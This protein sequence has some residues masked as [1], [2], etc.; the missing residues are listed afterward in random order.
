[1]AK[2]E[3]QLFDLILEEVYLGTVVL[4]LHSLHLHGI[5]LLIAIEGLASYFGVLLLIHALVLFPDLFYLL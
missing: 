2:V 3:L 5:S 4:H 1:M